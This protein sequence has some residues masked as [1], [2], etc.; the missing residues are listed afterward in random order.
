MQDSV[1]PEG[2]IDGCTV[3]GGSPHYP[4]TSFKWTSP[5]VAINPWLLQ[6]SCVTCSSSL[7]CLP[8]SH[9]HQH[10]QSQWMAGPERRMSCDGPELA[11]REEPIGCFPLWETCSNNRVVTSTGHSN[12]SARQQCLHRSGH[13]YDT[14]SIILYFRHL[15]L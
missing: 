11:M 9:K 1:K 3:A 6:G 10:T 14:L 8:L 13:E 4:S 15:I 2:E 12:I 7:P 5:I